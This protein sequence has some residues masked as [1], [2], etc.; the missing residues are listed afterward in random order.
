LLAADQLVRYA[1]ELAASHQVMPGQPS[2]DLLER[3]ASNEKALRDFQKLTL[4]LDADAVVTPAG[5]WLLDNFFMIEEQ[6]LMARRH[7][8]RGYCRQLPRLAS[9]PSKGLPR[10]Y[11]IALRLIS[12]LDAQIDVES[13]M[14]F[15]NEYQKVAPLRLGGALGSADYAA[16]RFAGTPATGV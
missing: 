2:N 8:P 7:L 1:G 3:L 6:I 16:A 13:A 4:A 5:V 14:N 11:D 10:V 15:L 12:H 9:G